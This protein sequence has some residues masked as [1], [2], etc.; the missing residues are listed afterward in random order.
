[1]KISTRLAISL[2][3]NYKY[4]EAMSD[5]PP[6]TCSSCRE[7]FETQEEADKHA[8]P[9]IAGPPDPKD[10]PA[11][12]GIYLRARCPAC[13]EHFWA[14][15]GDWELHAQ[16]HKPECHG[17]KMLG[18]LNPPVPEVVPKEL[19]GPHI[20]PYCLLPQPSLRDLCDHILAFGMDHKVMHYSKEIHSLYRARDY[21]SIPDLLSV[22]APGY[23][24]DR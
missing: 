3:F 14:S 24:Q 6:F 23:N 9:G 22:L 18:L 15:I 12:K 16:S 11:Y 10:N 7:V 8:D 20:C 4:S 5:N 13:P 1:M 21:P 17:R 2:E 19:G